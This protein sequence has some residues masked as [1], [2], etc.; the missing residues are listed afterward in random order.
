MEG[1]VSKRSRRGTS[2]C[3]EGEG[4]ATAV[5]ATFTDRRMDLVMMASSS[6]HEGARDV[7]YYL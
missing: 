2:L 4:R 6:R 3:R 7:V 5:M 1:M